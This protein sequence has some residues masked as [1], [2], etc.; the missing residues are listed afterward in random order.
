MGQ[1]NNSFDCC[2]KYQDWVYIYITIQTNSAM[3]ALFL[4]SENSEN[5]TLLEKAPVKYLR[6]ELMRRLQHMA[7]RE[8]ANVLQPTMNY[9][10]RFHFFVGND[11]R[12]IVISDYYKNN[13]QSLLMKNKVLMAIEAR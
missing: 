11:V 10:D 12:H 7:S 5:V 13:N 3:K 4:V 2:C 9:R 8:D 6:K 1:V